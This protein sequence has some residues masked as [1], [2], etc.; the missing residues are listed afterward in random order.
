MIFFLA[1]SASAVSRSQAHF[2]A[3][4]KRIHNHIR[5]AADN[6]INK[7]RAQNIECSFGCVTRSSVLLKPN[8]AHIPLFNISEQ[9]FVQHGPITIAI[10]YNALTYS[11][12]KKNDPIMHLDQNSHQ[13]VTRFG[14]VDF[15]MYASGISVPQMLVYIPA[16]I[17]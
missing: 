1:K 10:D 11:F 13:T 5:S 8:V 17:K 12:S 15:S 6:A 7:N 2:P 4:F 16:K 3:L 9:K 14:C